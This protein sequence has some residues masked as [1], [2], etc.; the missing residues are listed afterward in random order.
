MVE[1]P[2]FERSELL[3]RVL[4]TFVRSSIEKVV[5]HCTYRTEM[6]TVRHATSGSELPLLCDCVRMRADILQS[7]RLCRSLGERA[8]SGVVQQDNI[9]AGQYLHRRW[10]PA[11]MAFF[12]RR[13]RDHGKAEDLTQEVFVRMLDNIPDGQQPDGYIFRIAR[14]LLIDDSRRS[15]VRDRHREALSADTDRDLDVLDPHRR[16]EGRE[17]V[18]A[19][20]AALAEMPERMRTMLI[21]YRLEKLSQ[22]AIGLSYGISA[23]AVKQQLARAMAILARHM[24]DFR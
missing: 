13:V 8:G 6:V 24:R 14:N 1:R 15:V 18:A 12:L 5:H 7:I 3:C 4:K 11:L 16:A 23:S 2:E 19:L 9:P 20:V 21:L 22:D 17:Q 10:R